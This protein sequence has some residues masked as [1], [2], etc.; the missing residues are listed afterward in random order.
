M[1][2]QL[3][4]FPKKKKKKKSMNSTFHMAEFYS[5]YYTSIKLFKNTGEERPLW[6]NKIGGVLGAS[7][8]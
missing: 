1:L 6:C 5:V 7:G 8:M 4:K 2:L 3:S